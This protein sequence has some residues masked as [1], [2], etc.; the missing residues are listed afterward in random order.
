MKNK[1]FKIQNDDLNIKII[2]ILSIYS[3]QYPCNNISKSCS[4]YRKFFIIYNCKLQKK[5][6]IMFS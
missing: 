3:D 1:K 6:V 2:N 4:N 5:Y